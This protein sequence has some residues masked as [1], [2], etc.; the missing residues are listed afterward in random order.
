MLLSLVQLFHLF[1]LSLCLELVLRPLAQ[2]APFI[3]QGSA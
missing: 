2:L 3:A 1:H